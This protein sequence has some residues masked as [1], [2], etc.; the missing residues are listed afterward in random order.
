MSL[1]T[2]YWKYCVDSCWLAICDDVF[3]C[4]FETLEPE[5]NNL[6]SRVTDVNQVAEQLLSSDNRNK[7]KIHQTRDQLNNRSE[8]FK[9]VSHG[10]LFSLMAHFLD[11]QTLVWW[12]GVVRRWKEFEQLA[13]QKKQG[14]ESALNIQN[15]HLE[16]NEIQT[17]MKEK[18]KVIESTQSLGNDLA[19]VMAL[20]RKL[21][22][23]ERDLEAIQVCSC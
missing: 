18:T 8:R 15:Y 20:Q 21:T 11:D 9:T 5:M 2:V 4:R 1:W 23:M 3:G 16:C 6:G 22:G 13:G 14:L 10:N 17:W 7:D 19:G 12:F